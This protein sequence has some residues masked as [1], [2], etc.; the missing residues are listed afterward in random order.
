MKGRQKPNLILVPKPTAWPAGLPLSPA[1]TGR[2]RSGFLLSLAPSLPDW[3]LQII[4]A[5]LEYSLHYQLAGH[6]DVWV[7]YE[8]MAME[9]IFSLPMTGMGSE[10]M[11]YVA[12]SLG[13]TKLMMGHLDLAID[14]G[15]GWLSR[16]ARADTSDAQKYFGLIFSAGSRA[17][18]MW[19]LLRNPNEQY[20]VLCWLSKCLLLKTRYLFKPFPKC[21]EEAM[22]MSTLGSLYAGHR[23]RWGGGL[24]AKRTTSL[25]THHPLQTVLFSQNLTP[26]SLS[27]PIALA[28]DQRRSDRCPHC[29]DQASTPTR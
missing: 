14:L 4:K 26:L 17:Q 7:K 13:Y 3:P 15:K 27:H 22:G 19:A 29:G 1:D 6:K 16:M 8:V 10:I 24:T 11:A 23:G 9:Q 18:K 12:D 21:G 2:H 20:K 5:Y 25:V 28:S